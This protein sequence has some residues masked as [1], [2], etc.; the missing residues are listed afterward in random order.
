MRPAAAAVPRAG[1]RPVAT[2]R[3]VHPL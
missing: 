2:A 1:V 3:V